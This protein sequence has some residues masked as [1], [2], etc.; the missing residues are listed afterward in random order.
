MMGEEASTTAWFLELDFKWFTLM[1]SRTIKLAMSELNPTK[2]EEAVTFLEEVVYIFSRLSIYKQGQRECFKPFQAGMIVTTKSAL[3]LQQL[4]LQEKK[5]FKFLFISRTTQDCLKNLFSFI[6]QKNPVPR[7]LDFKVSL[8]LITLSQFFAPCKSGRYDEDP[9]EHLL[10]YMKT[11]PPQ[12][13]TSTD[14]DSELPDC[15]LKPISEEEKASLHYVAGAPI[16]RTLPDRTRLSEPSKM[17]SVAENS[18]NHTPDKSM[19][20]TNN[21][22]DVVDE[23]GWKAKLVIPPRDMRKKTSD[24]TDTKGNEFEDFCLKRELLMGIFEKGWEKP[25]PIQEASI[26]IALLGRDILARAKNGTG[27][28]GAYIIP[29]LQRIDVTKDHI[30]AMAIVPTRELALQTS[31]I[32]IELS[33]HLKA[34]VMVTTGGT[35]LKDDI[36]RIY[37]NGWLPASFF[38]PV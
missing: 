1:T 35:N 34:R 4:Y 10:S 14:E 26:P 8:R 13:K 24:V 33:K 28:T 20:H 27:K 16:P 19:N 5:K 32:C 7:A 2:Y 21:I 12:Q 18:D 22:R 31:Q 23:G 30:Q 17:S 29:M 15:L 25:S 37:E 38:A 6:R 36:M 11:K 9:A 3:K